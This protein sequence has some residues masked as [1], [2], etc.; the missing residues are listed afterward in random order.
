MAI[1]PESLHHACCQRNELVTV[2]D[3]K[4]TEGWDCWDFNAPVTTLSSPSA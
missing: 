1:S 2:S 3:G 4:I